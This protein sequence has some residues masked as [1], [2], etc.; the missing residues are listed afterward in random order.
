LAHNK[1]REGYGQQLTNNTCAEYINTVV[2]LELEKWGGH[3]GAK[4]NVGGQHKCLS[5]MVIFRCF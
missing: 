4:E 5:C 3:F 2:I 1:I